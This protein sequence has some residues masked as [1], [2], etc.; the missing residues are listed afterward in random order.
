MKYRAEIDGLRAIAVVPVILFHGGLPGFAG[1]YVGVDVFFVI[2]GYLISTLILQDLD[3]GQFSVV[4][5][6]ERRAR[7]ILPVLVF[8]MLACLPFAWALML[9]D[10]MKEFAQSALATA[11]FLA[12]VYFW[13]EAGYFATASEQQ[14][15]LHT[16][17]L[18][19]EEQFYILFPLL[20]ILLW[21]HR[22]GLALWVI[23][24][25]GLVSLAATEWGWRYAA[26]AN[27][28][29]LPTRA[30][31]L[32]AGV[33]AALYVRRHGLW[34]SQAGA[35]LGL[36]AIVLSI[37]LFDSTT[38]FPSL[39]ALLPV[40][41]TALVI[42][43]AAETTAVGRLLRLAPF[44][45][46]GLISY[47]AYLWHQPIFAFFRLWSP[48]EPG[49]AAML[50]LSG[51]ALGLAVLS[52]RFVERPFRSGALRA[53]RSW[54]TLVVSAFVLAGVVGLGLLGHR[55]N[56]FP[57]R[58]DA[59][60]LAVYDHRG[61]QNPKTGAC[62]VTEGQARLVH[63][64]PACSDFLTDGRADVV[65]IGDSHSNAISAPVQALLHAQGLASYASSYGGCIALPGFYRVDAS[66][67]HECDAYNRDMLAFAR[68]SGASTLVLTSRFPIYLLGTRFDNGE[69]GV[70]PGLPA[71]VD[72]LDGPGGGWD[73]P[74]RVARVQAAIQA[75]LETLLAEF[76]VILVDPIP[77]VGWITPDHMARCLMR[78][79]DGGC[80]L[81]TAHARYL[82]RTA[83]V[84][85]A[86]DAVSS[87]RLVRVRPDTV[88]CAG[89]RC[90]A[91][92]AGVPLY[93]DD[94]HLALSTGAPRVA[95]LIAEAALGLAAR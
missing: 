85:A 30:W 88:L 66:L 12:N 55:A 62:Q 18:A 8:V 50:A 28:Y 45:G 2:S 59:A 22:R 21:P 38:P 9:P 77:E 34:V 69:G 54:V 16:W 95:R 15:L 52:W 37:A 94:H 84:R 26:D 6:Y 35:A 60:L 93:Y 63:P 36:A 5:F 56:G 90:R 20:M 71:Y 73:D 86:F 92:E 24:G 29:L 3:A 4:T 23:V 70:E 68:Q 80:D 31:E 39:Y 89:G 10:Q 82:A 19:V 1:G 64:A 65:L 48:S 78:A 83:P 75:A 51:L 11:A 25:L 76:N 72:V 61:D 47:S 57:G 44:V 42:L 41:G 27:F 46:I 43:C 40:G 53:T 13:R 14:P 74:A 7:R 81:D 49:H 67:A 91:S 32:L 33:L 79:P 58:F 87:D 17:S